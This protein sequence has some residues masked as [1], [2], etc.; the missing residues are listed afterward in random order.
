METLSV[1][2]NRI[3]LGSK[4][5]EGGEG[6]VFELSGRPEQ[7]VK[8]YKQ[9]V[10]PSHAE[11]LNA[12]VACSTPEIQ[13]IA[14]WPLHI[15]SSN[16]GHVRGFVMRRVR[17]FHDL[18][19]L[20][21]PKTR[22]QRYPRADY[23]F[24]IKVA[25]NI[26]EGFAT[27]HRSGHV[28]GD[29]NPGGLSAASDGTVTFVDCDS[30]QIFHNGR[31]HACNVGIPT[32]QPP[33]MQ[34]LSTFRAVRRTQDHDGFGMAVLFFQLLFLG[35]HPFSG[36]HLKDE[37][38]PIEKAIKECRFAYAHDASKR[39]VKQ[40]PNSLGMGAV[41]LELRILFE[42]A[43]LAPAGTSRPPASDWLYALRK[44]EKELRSC[45]AN[46]AH[47]HWSGLS[48]CPLCEL[49]AKVGRALF[50]PDLATA[51]AARTLDL[52]ALERVLQQLEQVIQN[53]PSLGHAELPVPASVET[54][55]ARR[56]WIQRLFWSAVALS[57]VGFFAQGAAWWAVAAAC[58]FAVRAVLSPKAPRDLELILDEASRSAASARDAEGQLAYDEQEFRSRL[59]EAR[60]SMDT[61]RR[62]R[63]DQAEL[64]RNIQGALRK[65]ALDG[66]L[67]REMIEDH[68]IPSIGDSLKS[69]LASFGIETA[70]DVLY[71]FNIKVP[72][73]G[74][75]RRDSLVD[76]ARNL[77]RNFVYRP[78]AN[79]ERAERNRL[80]QEHTRRFNMA[81]DACAAAIRR[82]EAQRAPFESRRLT[83]LQ[84]IQAAN[85]MKELASRLRQGR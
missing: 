4:V 26:A 62:L 2:G 8:L 41:P 3:I 5:G 30:F 22:L 76:W 85:A 74:E 16:K 11:K 24:L 17:E 9:A 84:K 64:Q 29:V 82:A 18:H 83:L 28:V 6:S 75:R 7:L 27:I 54:Y 33:E 42:R 67:D 50:V 36:Q 63:G 77:S 78:D 23:K 57:S 20:Y 45:G 65:Q 49:E 52:P 81:A 19:H 44:F 56:R 58:A 15:V 48:A 34:E 32:H 1:N 46:P 37:D 39:L 60:A 13:S 10:E 68:S 72:G 38:L 35:R 73:I 25:V 61:V 59:R 80:T 31:I 53:R 47:Q 70:Y 21:S 66:Y 69:T 43:F 40:P 71:S 55:R 12:V 51:T 79:R 14:S